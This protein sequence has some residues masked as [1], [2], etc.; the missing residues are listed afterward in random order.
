M[1]ALGKSSGTVFPVD[2]GTPPC[3]FHV[4][5]DT[6]ACRSVMSEECFK[7]LG[8][9]KLSTVHLPKVQN[10]SGTDMGALGVFTINLCIGARHFFQKFIVCKKLTRPVILGRDFSIRNCVGI[11][12]TKRGTKKLT[13]DDKVLLE[14]AEEGVQS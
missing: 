3:K 6:G 10:A 13:V 12:W 11:A 2:I 5:F 4:L 8:G 7:L 14:L 1:L 9:G